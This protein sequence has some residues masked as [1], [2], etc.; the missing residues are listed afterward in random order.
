[1]LRN[2]ATELSIE[3]PQ[4]SLTIREL[5]NHLNQALLIAH[6]EGKKVLLIIEEA[7]LLSPPLLE[8][9][10]LLTNLETDTHKL[11]TILLV[12]QP[13]L[14]NTLASP[15]LRQLQQRIIARYHLPSLSMTEVWRYLDYRLQQ[16][17]GHGKQISMMARW[18]LY[19]Y[20]KG[21]PRVI[22]L[23]TD[24]ALRLAYEDGQRH[25]Y[26]THIRRAVKDV[27]FI[28]T[29]TNRIRFISILF[30]IGL[31]GGLAAINYSSLK[32]SLPIWQ[33]LEVFHS[34]IDNTPL[35]DITSPQ[36][37][38]DQVNPANAKTTAKTTAITTD[39]TIAIS[40]WHRLLK[41]WGQVEEQQNWVNY[42][43][44]PSA[45]LGCYQRS[46][47]RLKDLRQFNLPALLTWL[48]DMGKTQTILLHALQGE[49]I[50]FYHN[51][52]LQ[53]QNIAEFSQRWLGDIRLLWRLPP[54]Y[55]QDLYPNQINLKLLNWVQN[56]L[57]D[58]HFL[59]ER[60]ITGGRYNELL[61]I[62]VQRFQR[63]HGLT[64]DG[65]LGIRTL[66]KMYPEEQYQMIP[67][68]NLLTNVP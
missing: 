17:G 16:V 50:A 10:R 56:A 25:V 65:I 36:A 60:L 46:F 49:Q 68:L 41:Q 11:L 18:S 31:L 45:G 54:G 44:Q 35:I 47:N 52:Q 13:E 34:A 39:A 29:D 3:I 43:R 53:W 51:N 58:Q 9:L 23:L 40:P 20:T 42:C 14:L 30:G 19:R 38:Q 57:L 33:E 15:T 66:L 22:N 67:W 63:A 2:I 8:M 59:S 32:T 37:T 28:A 48:D 55:E 62:A 5:I 1:M 6:S 21:V 27:G 26:S 4:S 12:G 7:Q 24:Q 64:A 61:I